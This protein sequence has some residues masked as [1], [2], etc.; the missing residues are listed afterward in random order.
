LPNEVADA[1]AFGPVSRTTVPA[2]KIGS[3]IFLATDVTGFTTLAERLPP[4]V[5]DELVKDYF[6]PLIETTVR[7][8]GNILNLTGESM[9]CAWP[10]DIDPLKARNSAI[11]ATLEMAGLI[12][13]FGERHPSSPMPTRFGV[14]A[15]TAA[16][17]VV[18]GHGRYVTTVVGDVANTVA[19]I[20]SLNKLLRTR[21]LVSAEVLANVN[22]LILRPLGTFAPV[23]K[24]E[25]V[26]LIEILGLAAEDGRL[27]ALAESFAL[28]LA[29]F[30]AERWGDAANSFRALQQDYPED[31]PASYFL[32]LADPRAH[33]D[34]EIDREVPAVARHP[35]VRAVMRERQRALIDFTPGPAGGG[36]SAKR[37]GGSSAGSAK[38]AGAAKKNVDDFDDDIPF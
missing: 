35:S 9:M 23:G 16:F 15:G 27:I 6:G 8:G 22:G 32:A 37:E 34:G 26:D 4:Q 2:S 24:S 19:R 10:T 33:F 13:K 38:P 36:G 29:A 5:L 31:G 1:L 12:R 3:A 30:D 7:H 17:G 11:T 18:G 28:A 25:S 20:D 21:I 14:R